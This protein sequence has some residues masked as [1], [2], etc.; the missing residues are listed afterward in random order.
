[1]NLHLSVPATVGNLGSGFD[2][3]GMAVE[4]FNEVDIEVV[5]EPTA[6]GLALQIEG[7]G[8]QSLPTDE[9]HLLVRILREQ[10]AANPELLARLRIRQ[11]NRIPLARGLGSSATV[12]LM[13]LMAANALRTRLL[14]ADQL[15]DGQLL[16]QALP[17]EG[18][19]D[20]LVPALAGGVCL[21]WTEA[22]QTRF[23]RLPVP[24]TV[25]VVLVVPD[26][27]IVTARARQALPAQ[28]P[29]ADA[30]FNISRAC[31]LVASLFRQ[32]PA[33]LRHALEDRLHQ[34]Y[35]C[36]LLPP[37]GDALQAALDAGALGAAVSGSGSTMLA[38]VP[39]GDPV[40][41]RITEKMMQP[42]TNAAVPCRSLRV[43]PAERGAELTWS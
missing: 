36:E 1:M 29:L 22:D 32:E 40:A 35:R 23:L 15:T 3:L 25:D 11:N 26:R 42:F 43:R 20:N 7:E 33:S 28:V 5:E 19:P 16:H 31:L 14:R 4:L 24:H 21:S 37:M 9:G 12:I 39:S 8:A 10:L 30:V 6:S 34:S 27:P 38:F 18:H 41:E 2:V 17:F 13:G